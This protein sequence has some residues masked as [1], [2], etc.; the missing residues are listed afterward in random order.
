MLATLTG[1]GPLPTAY[2]GCHAHGATEMF[3][4]NPEGGEVEVVGS[5]EDT[6]TSLIHGAG[7]NSSGD[8]E[9][10]EEENCHFH[11]GVE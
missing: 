2:N 11:A 5:T 3:C 10:G 6:D 1:S 4:V 8:A 7:D 9:S